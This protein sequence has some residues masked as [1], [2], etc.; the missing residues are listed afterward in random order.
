MNFIE[1]NDFLQVMN[2]IEK[3]LVL[4]KQCWQLYLTSIHNNQTSRL[5]FRFALVQSFYTLL[6][7][8][9][10]L[11]NQGEVTTARDRSIFPPPPPSSC[12]C[13]ASDLGHPFHIL[14]NSA[15]LLH[16]KWF[17]CRANSSCIMSA[18]SFLRSIASISI[19]STFKF[20]LWYLTIM[21]SS[22]VFTF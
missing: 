14:H 2:F 5:E 3:Q 16:T 10:H 11:L 18:I 7:L 8:L 9:L 13:D 12:N 6:M 19:S 15:S 17:I 20:L 22:C 1:N 21:I 4:H